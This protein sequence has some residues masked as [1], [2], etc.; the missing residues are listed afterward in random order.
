MTAKDS[1]ATGLGYPGRKLAVSGYAD[2]KKTSRPIK[3]SSH[4]AELVDVVHRHVQRE[5]W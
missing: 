2:I 3:Q 1:R 4:L 5:K